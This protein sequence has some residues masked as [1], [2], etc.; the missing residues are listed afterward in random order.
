[1]RTARRI[2]W[3]RNE[4]GAFET[5]SDLMKLPGIGETVYEDIK[6]NFEPGPY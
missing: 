1:M 2:K 6:E 5:K 3:Y 4:V